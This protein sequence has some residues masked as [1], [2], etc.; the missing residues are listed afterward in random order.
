VAFRR[1][2]LSFYSCVLFKIMWLIVCSSCSL[3][4]HVEL[5]IILNPWRYDLVCVC[6]CGGRHICTYVELFTCLLVC[7]HV[8]L[9]VS[10]TW[11]RQH[12]WGKRAVGRTMR[13]KPVVLLQH[14]QHCVTGASEE[15]GQ[16]ALGIHQ[17]SG[18]VRKL[19]SVKHNY[20]DHVVKAAEVGSRQTG[21]SCSCCVN[22]LSLV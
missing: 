20:P 14:L 21:C 19:S 8:Y 5:G 11:E 6:V 15:T 13:R 7:K 17:G 9:F 3:Q 2:L 1:I 12:N 4:G 18:H 22:V 16:L 10:S